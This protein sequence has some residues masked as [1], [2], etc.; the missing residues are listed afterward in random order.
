MKNRKKGL[1]LSYINIILSMIVGIF[2]SSFYIRTLGNV[3]YGIYESMSSFINYLVLLEFGTGTAM[4]KNLSLCFSKGESNLQIKKNISTIWFVTFIL[5]I[6]IVLVGIIF[7]L[8]I[9]K[10]YIESMT[11]L[12][13]VYA[14][15]IF[16]FMLFYM[17][18]SF[19]SQTMNGIILANENYTYS[20]KISIIKII[21]KFVL[22]IFLIL[23]N[24]KAI[25]I[26]IVDMIISIF[27]F[28]YTFI[29]CKKNYITAFSFKYFDL[30]IFKNI[31]PFCFAMFLQM[32]VN[33]ANTNVDKFVIS[34]MLS[35]KMVTL[36]S[37]ALYI[38]SM[39]SSATTIPITMYSPQVI[40]EVGIGKK[41]KE[42]AEAL[43]QPC[44]LIVMIGG[45][46]LFGFI[47]VGKQF[48]LMM[49]GSQYIEVWFLAILLMIPAFI[50]MSNGVIVNVLNA[51]NKRMIRS[52]I[53]LFTTILNI[54]LTILWIKNYGIIGATFATFI[55]NFLGQIILMNI[56]YI[57]KI[58]LPI[59]YMF[60]KTFKGI[61]FFQIISSFISYFIAN[62]VENVF[63]SFC[64]GGISF[65]FLF[66]LLYIKFGMN[67]IELNYI[68]LLNKRIKYLFRKLKKV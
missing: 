24:K 40:K 35:P 46:L 21:S 59:F 53:L 55:C 58:K 39:F 1:L 41:G 28:F 42:L 26:A 57:K 18:F 22:I 54:I 14:K 43:V 51:L 49:Y 17:L 61:L 47:T 32:I 12:Q 19:Y 63:F 20:S 16:I 64:I 62:L 38:Y 66:T 13:I 50:N 52:F 3:E 7:Y 8:L 45:L 25:Y 65:L 33:Q 37:I 30:S 29:F 34:V 6:L 23:I 10:I 60:K 11:S 9:E 44:R 36:Y 5:S 31:L 56:Y 68:S 15:K 27:L 2:L 67:D 48:I 4:T